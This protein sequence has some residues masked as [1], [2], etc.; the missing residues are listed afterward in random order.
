MSEKYTAGTFL[1]YDTYGICKISEVKKMT[2]LKGTPL[3]TYY[4]LSPLNSPSS[5]FYVPA[6]N[7]TLA[8]KL[9]EP[10]SER[11]IKG[12]LSESEKISLDWIDNR[13]TRNEN[14]RRILD[15]GI[16]PELIALIRCLYSRKTQLQENGKKLSGTDE[17]IFT[18][19][20]KLVK[21]EFAFSLKIESEKVAEY[22]QSYLES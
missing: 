2:F 6:D 5:T 13:Q 7:E 17:G 14:F 12:L 1:V 21:E 10:M 18:S 4:V 15:G 16:T 20:E 9:R 22:I 8:G 3:Q 19:A 11:E